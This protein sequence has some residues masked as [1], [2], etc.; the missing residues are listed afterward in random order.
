MQDN[1]NIAVIV[2]SAVFVIGVA[3]VRRW[4]RYRKIRKS[5]ANLTLCC[6]RLAHQPVQA[7][8]TAREI[9]LSRFIAPSHVPFANGR[10]VRLRPEYYECIKQIIYT[11]SRGE[12]SVIAYVDKVLKA[13]LE[14]NGAV[15]D[16][17]YEDRA[18][19]LSQNE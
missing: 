3:F 10:A 2:I 17:L 5:G 8:G 4:M 1:L 12:V 7:K 6:K 14:D 15:I 19:E 16:A 11:I 9:Y 18:R 13:H